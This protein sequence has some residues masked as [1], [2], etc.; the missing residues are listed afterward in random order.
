MAV[1]TYDPSQVIISVGGIPMSGFA[2]GTFVSIM[3]SEDAYSKI[4]GAD[5]VTS[6]AKSSDKSGEMTL[7][8]AQTSPS[9]DVLSGIALADELTNGGVVPIIVKDAS[10]RTNYFSGNGWI[11]KTPEAAFGKEVD[12]R[13]WTFDLADLDVFAGGNG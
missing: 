5:G 6:R 3:R 8:L 7:T 9:N 2:D 12:N 10:G 1:L 11:R 13:E 4:N